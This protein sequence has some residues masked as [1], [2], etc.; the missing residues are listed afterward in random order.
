MGASRGAVA[1]MQCC[2]PR[3]LHCRHP[4]LHVQRKACNTTTTTTLLDACAPLEVCRSGWMHVDWFSMMVVLSA[5]QCAVCAV[6]SDRLTDLAISSDCRWLLSAGMDC[7]LRVWD[8][9][10]AQCLQVGDVW[11]CRVELNMICALRVWNITLHSSHAGP[12]AQCL[13]QMVASFS[14][15]WLV[16]EQLLLQHK[17]CCPLCA[18]A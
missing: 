8:I 18:V 5:V 1:G 2:F 10:A 12:A 7:T 4:H 14:T 11:G 3:L 9:P 16:S 15:R 17:S 6:C 13:P